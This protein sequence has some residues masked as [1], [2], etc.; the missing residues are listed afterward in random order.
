M[1]EN[2]SQS[3]SN[4]TPTNQPSPIPQ[5]PH[6]S[7]ASHLKKYLIAIFIIVFLIA[8]T[9]TYFVLNARKTTPQKPPQLIAK[10]LL[11]T[12]SQVFTN[13]KEYN[14]NIYGFQ[15]MYESMLSQASCKTKNG[16]T[17]LFSTQTP[18]CQTE[19]EN[20]PIN[21]IVYPSSEDDLD[22]YKSEATIHEQKTVNVNGINAQ[23][24]NFTASPSG[25]PPLDIVITRLAYKNNNYD[26]VLYDKSYQKSYDQILSTFKFTTPSI[27]PIS[28]N[29]TTDTSN[30]K[31][32]KDSFFSFNYP[33]YWETSNKYPA[34]SSDIDYQVSFSIP[35]LNK[36]KIDKGP[37]YVSISV[38]NNE[39]NL[40]LEKWV[41]SYASIYYQDP[42]LE[43]EIIDGEPVIKVPNTVQTY[44]Y[45]YTQHTFQNKGKVLQLTFQPEWGAKSGYTD[46]NDPF[47][48]EEMKNFYLLIDSFKF[49][50]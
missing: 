6:F 23:Q 26:I 47:V 12:P 16:M 33:P 8:G 34:Q 39:R 24:L 20:Y 11:P 48:K 9:G 46:K 14:D 31:T 32:Y 43:N 41:Y 50:R 1:E 19:F 7:A 10:D 37:L 15:F 40:S 42:V 30:W 44:L 21:I 18:N 35:N 3:S 17:L 38:Y 27:T 22:G 25:L 36:P 13:V 29:Q 45:L 28:Q 5:N 4:L 2:N 49:N